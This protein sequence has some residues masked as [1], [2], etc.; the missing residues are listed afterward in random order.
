MKRLSKYLLAILCIFVVWQL[1]AS[2][3]HLR[4][5]PTPINVIKYMISN[6]SSKIV[7]HTLYSLRRLFAGIAIAIIVGYPL[8]IIIG[9]SKTIEKFMSPII[10]FLYPIPKI[11]FL[12]IFMI[13]FGLGD[14]S[15]IA[16]IVVIIIFQIIVYSR[17]SIMALDKE[18]FYTLTALNC[19]GF[20]IFRHILV[21]ASLPSLLS[22]TRISL[23]TS[24]AVLFFS[25]TIGT[26]YGLGFFITDSMVRINYPAMYSG[27][28]VLSI[29]GFILFLF[30]DVLS[31]T[32][33]R[34]KR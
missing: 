14:A 30:I 20:T 9:Y 25:E 12:P 34:W 5:F 3:A 17:D 27:I 1:I 23:A 11:T 2:I 16:T 18:L 31:F 29:V 7:L 19:K 15:K 28:L 6:F 13:M 24:M 33:L 26:Q 8:G 22:A 4:F 21:P 10:Y 32:L